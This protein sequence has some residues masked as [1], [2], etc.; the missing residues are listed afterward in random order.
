MEK[1][2]SKLS[3]NLGKSG[4]SLPGLKL[5]QVPEVKMGVSY[6]PVEPRGK[7]QQEE[8]GGMKGTHLSQQRMENP[9]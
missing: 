3:T 6:N 8:E 4:L 2:F 9:S 1:P 7:V 5:W